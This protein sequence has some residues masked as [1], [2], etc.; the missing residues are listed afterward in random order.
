MRGAKSVLVV[1]RIDSDG[2]IFGSGLRERGF[3]D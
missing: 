1:E 3:S 2:V